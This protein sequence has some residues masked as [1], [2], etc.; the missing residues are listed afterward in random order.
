MFY[1]GLSVNYL[2]AKVAPLKKLYITVYT[3]FC[4]FFEKGEYA[5]L[6]G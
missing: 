6:N 3:V 1:H 5:I 4:T 2:T